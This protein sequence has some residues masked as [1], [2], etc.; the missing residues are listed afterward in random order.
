[1]VSPPIMDRSRYL[2]VMAFLA[3]AEG[4]HAHHS[5]GSSDIGGGDDVQH[6]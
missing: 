4:K 6:A 3:L 1:M 2:R 5:L